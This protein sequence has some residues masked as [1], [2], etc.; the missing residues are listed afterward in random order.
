MACFTCGRLLY[1]G[2]V[3]FH[4][5]SSGAGF[6]DAVSSIS[7]AHVCVHNFQRRTYYEQILGVRDLIE[8]YV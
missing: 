1:S 2:I 8:S 7:V 3:L 6:Y 4:I 5:I